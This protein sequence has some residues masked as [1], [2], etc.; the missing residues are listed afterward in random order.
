MNQKLK[1]SEKVLGLEDDF[2]IDPLHFL[3]PT[4]ELVCESVQ[5]TQ[6]SSGFGWH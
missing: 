1:T 5:K 6:Q 3:S 2:P 4:C